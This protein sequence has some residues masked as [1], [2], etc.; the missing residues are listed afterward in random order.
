MKIIPVIHHLTTELTLENAKIC[1]EENAF[2]VFLI[3]MT[4]E[5]E[6]L[7]MLAKII[8]GQYPKLKVG[9][10]LLGKSAISSLD[11]SQ[12]FDL[13][14][15]WSDNPIIT[16]SGIGEE[17]S[18]IKSILKGKEHMFFNSVAFKYQ[19]S[20]GNPGLAAELS[21]VCGFI[22]TTSGKATGSAADLA[23]IIQMKSAIG[24]YPLAVAS[25]LDPENITGYL[26]YLEY[27]LVATGISKTFH[28]LDQD[29][30]RLIIQ[31]SV[32]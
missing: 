26:D 25:G 29:K 2:G 9:I 7:P 15:T 22:P 1:A 17:A 10:N 16:S 12:V 13:D 4:C 20:D 6:D 27:G 28:E 3:S 8:K 21:K 5:N 24:E 14:M 23:K 31:K 11:M 30:L 32:K 18:Y 19:K